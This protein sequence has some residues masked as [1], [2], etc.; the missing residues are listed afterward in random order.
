MLNHRRTSKT[1]AFSLIIIHIMQQ[2]NLYRTKKNSGVILVVVVW[3]LLILTILAIG[4]GRMTTIEIALTNYSLGQLRAKYMAWA[5]VFYAINLI[6]KDT[7]DKTTSQFDSL[8]Q[9]AVSLDQ[10]DAASF[11]KIFKNIALEERFFCISYPK[12][13]PDA[14]REQEWYGF[15]DE[16]RKINLNALTPENYL[17][18]RRLLINLGVEDATARTIAA[19]VIDWK[20]AD[21]QIT[22]GSFGAEDA[23]YQGLKP[24]YHCKNM[25][26]D[27]VEELLLVK[28][29]TLKILEQLKDYVTVFPKDSSALLINLNTASGLVIQSVAESLSGV[30]TNTEMSDA[31]SLSDKIIAYR[32]GSDLQIMTKDDRLIE[33]ND[34]GL[35][36]K[37]TAIFLSLQRYVTRVSRYI[38]VM[39]QG[40]DNSSKAQSKMEAVIDRNTLSILSWRSNH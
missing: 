26:F 28:G 4:V 30:S 11:T 14:D 21:D 33:L 36:P 8:Y 38:R 25:P 22:N 15:T 19:S 31:K 18:L 6:Q 1:P 3:I 2:K 10:N 29:M 20:D 24:P 5:G 17:I 27:N 12:K 16:E 23:Y 32:A 34:M 13:N 40:V 35:N 39:V 7:A 9:C 37:E